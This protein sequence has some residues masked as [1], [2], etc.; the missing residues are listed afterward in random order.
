MKTGQSLVALKLL[1]GRL[2]WV[3]ATSTIDVK[4][5]VFE[6]PSIDNQSEFSE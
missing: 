3:V 6:N 5:R 1:L 2:S 4:T